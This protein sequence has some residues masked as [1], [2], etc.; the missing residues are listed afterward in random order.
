MKS[1]R[2]STWGRQP[3]RGCCGLCGTSSASRW[4]RKFIP[5]KTIC[6]VCYQKE[7]LKNPDIT[8]TRR[9]DNK[10]SNK[11]YKG[12]VKAA[13]A[14]W[15]EFPISQEEWE[16]KTTECFYCQ[17]D[18]T[19]KSGTK[20]DRVDNSLGYTNENTVGCCRQ[21]NVSKNNHS[22][23]NFKEWVKRVYDKFYA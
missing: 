10:N 3:Y 20:L 2:P 8:K 21:C 5:D 6:R 18:L 11:G 19:Q 1:K 7:R 17:S 13:K 22:L 4:Y 12:A 9:Q 14:K 23:E 16:L 15:M